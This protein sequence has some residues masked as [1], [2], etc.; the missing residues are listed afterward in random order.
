MR[1]IINYCIQCVSIEYWPNPQRGVAEAY[2]V[3]KPGGIACMIGPV[4]PTFWL[5][6]LMADLWMLFPEEEDYFH[7]FERAGFQDI[8]LTRVGPKWYRG[9]RRHGLII[10]CSVTGVKRA[11]GESPLEVYSYTHKHH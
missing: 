4:R 10:G 6:R 9:V 7:W 8:K 5:S 11:S 1:L 3:L 2:R